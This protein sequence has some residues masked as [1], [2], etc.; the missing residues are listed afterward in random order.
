LLFI[1]QLILQS[2]DGVGRQLLVVGNDAE[3]GELINNVTVFA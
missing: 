2:G 3:C 1:C